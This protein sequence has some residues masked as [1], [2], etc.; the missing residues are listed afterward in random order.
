MKEKINNCIKI[1]CSMKY[2]IN[3][4]KIQTINGGKYFQKIYMIKYLL[5][6]YYLRTA[7]WNSSVERDS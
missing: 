6:K 1:I 4:M 5:L 3:R 2:N 7:I